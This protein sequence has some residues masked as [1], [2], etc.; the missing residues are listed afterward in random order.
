VVLPAWGALGD[1][2]A[3]LERGSIM[4]RMSGCSKRSVTG[5]FVSILVLTFAMAQSAIAVGFGG[6]LD[7]VIQVRGDTDGI[8]GT[9]L[10][11]SA[12]L[13]LL[14][15]GLGGDSGAFE[16]H[17]AHAGDYV[18][19]AVRKLY[20]RTH[21]GGFDVTAGRQPV[22]WGFGSLLNPMDHTLGTVVM[23]EDDPGRFQ[24]AVEVHY[25]VNW[26]S[27]VSLVASWPADAQHV[28]YGGRV[29]FGILGYDLTV[30]YVREPDYSTHKNRK[31]P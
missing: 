8:Q 26:N 2:L 11:N 23:D 20:A 18:G 31:E 13:E 10:S 7:T 19:A 4:S 12:D 21:V 28:K 27:A 30:A 29:R 9:E 6:E 16:L 15:P 14:F 17:L 22:S 3:G 1:H 24:D 25:P 5:V